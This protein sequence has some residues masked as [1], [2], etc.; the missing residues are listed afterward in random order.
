MFWCKK[1]RKA[2]INVIRKRFAHRKSLNSVD[3]GFSMLL[4]YWDQFYVSP[5]PALIELRAVYVTYSCAITAF[6]HA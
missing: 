5:V 3:L 4:H 2:N 1:Q 6:L